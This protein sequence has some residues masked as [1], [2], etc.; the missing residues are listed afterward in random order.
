MIPRGVEANVLDRSL[1]VNEFELQSRYCSHF[2]TNTFEKG[3]K[4]II[5]LAID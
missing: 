2:R 4:P 3:M 1:E 5:P